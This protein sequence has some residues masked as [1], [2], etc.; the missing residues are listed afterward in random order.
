MDS[1]L[2]IDTSTVLWAN[3][4]V[5]ARP[6]LDRFIE[7][8]IS[9]YFIPVSFSAILLGL[10]FTGSSPSIRH[11]NQLTVLVA[12][13]ALGVV[14]AWIS[15][16]NSS[17]FRSRPFVDLDLNLLFYEPTDS[18]FPA[19][20]IA[21]ACAVAAGVSRKNPR[22]GIPLYI[23]AAMLGLGRMYAGVFYPT[24][25]LAGAMLGI[26]TAYFM[27]LVFHFLKPLI[28]LALKL[29]RSAHLA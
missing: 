16:L 28:S 23:A 12:A 17:F 10:W 3:Q 22:L 19:N 6:L 13:S 2:A 15:I 21:V 8:F 5:G 18:S 14:N 29:I 24:D 9:D 27:A 1:V 20:P 4:W 7:V 25:L 26:A 11:Q